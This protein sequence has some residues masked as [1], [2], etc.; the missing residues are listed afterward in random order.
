MTSR[1]SRPGGSLCSLH[2]SPCLLSRAR[3]DNP[4]SPA[5]PCDPTR[6]L[7][8][9]THFTE[10]KTQPGEF[11]SLAGGRRAAR[12]RTTYHVSP[13]GGNGL[14]LQQEGGGSHGGG[15]PNSHQVWGQI[16]ET[17]LKSLPPGP[18]KKHRLLWRGG[19]LRRGRAKRPPALLWA[20]GP[21]V[22]GSPAC[23]Q[24]GAG[25]LSP[26]SSKVPVCVPGGN[27]AWG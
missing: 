1:G 24:C 2:L 27:A 11:A 3:K 20:P 10:W 9:S 7:L 16:T 14:P 4:A 18:C 12:S 22:Q 5:C 6:Y 26:T 13:R 15:I 23:G 19:E 21:P 8:F 25:F 17:D